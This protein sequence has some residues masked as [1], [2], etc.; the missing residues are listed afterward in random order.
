MGL[1]PSK[2]S[3]YMTAPTQTSSVVSLD[4]LLSFAY[5]THHGLEPVV[6]FGKKLYTDP[7]SLV[8]RS[9]IDVSNELA[10]KDGA[11]AFAVGVGPCDQ[12]TVPTLF[13]WMNSDWRA[14]QIPQQPDLL[15]AYDGYVKPRNLK[16]TYCLLAD[17]NLVI[18]DVVKASKQKGG[19]IYSAKAC[20][21][22]ATGNSA[23]MSDPTTAPSS[24]AP[25]SAPAPAPAPTPANNHKWLFWL[26]ILLIIILIIWAAVHYSR[27]RKGY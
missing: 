6:L 18:T 9:L 4:D 14:T 7:C 16:A 12:C 19:M 25:S 10:N 17:K 1:T 26:I 21:S 22:T 3:Q 11:V 27:K 2:N 20:P 13:W 15:K 5:G 8:G 23:Y 24:A